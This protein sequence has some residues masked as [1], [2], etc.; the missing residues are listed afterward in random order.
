VGKTFRVSTWILL[1]GLLVTAGGGCVAAKTFD[2]DT[3]EMH[4]QGLVPDQ[5]AYLNARFPDVPFPQKFK[6]DRDKSFVYE[7]GSGGVKVGRLFFSGWAR[8]D[9]AVS[10]YHNEM[11]NKGWTL[12][13][14]IEH[15]GIM[16]LYDKKGWV[17]TIILTASLGQANVEIQVGPK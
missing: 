15:E 14:A 7:T 4:K 3:G 5:D 6:F 13:R 12:V 1:G 10:F 8:L 9:D 17:C 2:P 11:I 16:M